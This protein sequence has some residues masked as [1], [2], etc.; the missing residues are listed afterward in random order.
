MDDGQ[1]T[2]QIAAAKQT[3]SQTHNTDRLSRRRH[4]RHPIQLGDGV[5]GGRKRKYIQ[6][7]SLIVNPVVILL[8]HSISHIIDYSYINILYDM[9][10]LKT[11]INPRS[12]KTLI[13]SLLNVF[14][15]WLKFP[16]ISNQN[17]L[18]LQHRDTLYDKVNK[19]Y[20]YTQY[21]INSSKV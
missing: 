12:G 14:N 8:C 18:L 4:R 1:R 11:F 5:G 16:F 9:W 15:R 7:D 2:C 17:H 19:I 10:K 6:K 3:Q 20:V 13:K 21:S